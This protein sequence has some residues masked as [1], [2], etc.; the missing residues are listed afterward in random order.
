MSGI[1]HEVIVVGAGLSGLVAARALKRAGVDALVLEARDRVGGQWIGPTQDKVAALAAELGV[2]TFRH[3]D[4]GKKVMDVD[5]KVSTYT[6]LIPKLSIPALLETE[7]TMRR[8]DRWSRKLD[9]EAP[10]DAARAEAWDA[11]DVESHLQE[12]VKRAPVRALMRIATQ[13]IFAAEPRELSLLYFLFYLRSGGGLKRL[14]SVKDGAQQDRFVGGAQQLSEKLAA[15]LDVRLNSPVR[16]VAYDDEGATLS[17]DDGE[18]RCQRVIVAVPPA[19]CQRIEFSPALPRERQRAHEAMPMGKAI[20]YIV[21]YERAFWQESGYSGEVIADHGDVRL[22][23]DECQEEGRH[24][25]LLVFLV[26]DVAAELGPLDEGAR[27]ARVLDGL[28]RYF[29]D[30]AKD[31]VEI[32]EKDWTE[33]PW[34]GGCYVG[35]MGPGVMT[36]VGAALRAP[37]GRVHFAGT[38]T[39]ERW[40]GYMDGAVEA[41]ARAA[42]EVQRTMQ[43]EDARPEKSTPSASATTEYTSPSRKTRPGSGSPVDGSKPKVRPVLSST[44]P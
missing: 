14:A 1:D 26:G 11:V 24:P 37:V 39:A 25:A 8:L 42:R 43:G 4:E 5:G 18:L 9:V 3:H 17:L 12:T 31:A 33:D 35:L 20:K 6:G 21:A 32:A 19:V 34:S 13:A 38:E 30:E 29:G 28:A 10:W 41:G 22:V 16:R 44:P 23:F 15:G 36:E 7:W 2:E 27:K 40:A